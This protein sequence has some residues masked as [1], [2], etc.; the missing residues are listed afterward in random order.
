MRSKKLLNSVLSVLIIST[1][2]ISL[3]PC[4]RSDVQA[5]STGN[6]DWAQKYIEYILLHQNRYG[7]YPYIYD[8][9]IYEKSTFELIYL[10]DDDIPEILFGSGR[11]E[12]LYLLYVYNDEVNYYSFP[13]KA[14]LSYVERGGVINIHGWDWSNAGDVYYD[15]IYIFDKGKIEIEAYGSYYSEH[16]VFMWNNE[17]VSEEQYN[18]A[19]GKYIDT[20]RLKGSF[21]E[22]DLTY[23]LTGILLKI[24][25]ESIEYSKVEWIKAYQ[26]FLVHEK[27]LNMGQYY[28]DSNSVYGKL[29]DTD[30]NGILELIL[31]EHVYTYRDRITYLGEKSDIIDLDNETDYYYRGTGTHRV[32]QLVEELSCLDE[33]ERE[34]INDLSDSFAELDGI[35]RSV[36]RNNGLYD[37]RTVTK[38]TIH[39]EFFVTIMGNS[40][41]YSEHSVKRESISGRTDPRGEIGYG[42]AYDGTDAD[43]IL[44]NI[45]NFSDEGIEALHKISGS[46]MYYDNNTYYS[47]PIDDGGFIEYSAYLSSIEN[48][49]G[50]YHIKY[51][52][53]CYSD[54][55]ENYVYTT[56]YALAAYKKIDGIGYWSLYIVDDKPLHDEAESIDTGYIISDKYKPYPIVALRSKKTGKYVTCDIG[57]K[58]DGEY[59][60]INDP[61]FNVNADKVNAYEMFY[62]VPLSDGHVA[63]QT[64]MSKKY[65]SVSGKVGVSDFVKE[66]AVL[67]YTGS[68]DNCCIFSVNKWLREK[69]GSLV[70]TD[71]NKADAFEIVQ[72]SSNEYSNEEKN[73]LSSGEWLNIDS[74]GVGYWHIQNQIGIVKGENNKNSEENVK[75]LRELGYTLM[76]RKDL[77]KNSNTRTIEY[78]NMQC[79]IGVKKVEGI[80]DV[81]VVF[82]GTSGYWDMTSS[83]D[84]DDVDYNLWYDLHYGL[85]VNKDQRKIVTI[86]KGYL[87]MC[88]KLVRNNVDP[89]SDNYTIA[90]FD[91]DMITLNELISLAAKGE[92]NFTILGHSMGG[93]IAQCYALY[94]VDCGIPP[95]RIRGRTFNSALAFADD[96]ACDWFTDWYNLCVISDS[97]P[98]GLVPGSFMEYGMHRLGK[99]IWLYDDEPEKIDF[100]TREEISNIATEKHNMDAVIKSIL[101]ETA[102]RE[103]LGYT[104]VDQ[105]CFFVTNK[106]NV[107]VYDRPKKD[108]DPAYRIED[109][110]T[111]VEI[112]SFTYNDVGNKWYKTKD[113]KF[114]Y[115]N[116]LEVLEKQPV[117]IGDMKSFMVASNKAVLRKGCYNDTEV[118]EKLS[119]DTL[120]EADYGVTNGSGNFWIHTTVNGKT[121]WIYSDHLHW[122]G[123]LSS[124]IYDLVSRIVVDCPVDV[125][126]YDADDVLVASIIDGEVYTADNT[127]INPYMVGSGKYFDIHSDETYRVKIDSLSEG[128]MDYT[129]L[130]DYDA[131]T[132]EFASVKKYEAVN[133]SEEELFE[134]RFGGEISFG[135]ITLCVIDNEGNTVSEIQATQTEESGSVP[136]DL[137]MYIWITAIISSGVLT[138]VIMMI[139]K[140]YDRL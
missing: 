94:L 84:I 35:L 45:Y 50:V 75:A 96:T 63:L 106:E 30:N 31:N 119:V 52:Q 13:R 40:S 73:I 53:I 88:L 62:L 135:D 39:Y 42:G 111:V 129:V 19:Y 134:S 120:I 100:D 4:L 114:I 131:K 61:D 110:H 80:Y 133:L 2:I 101:D 83:N 10:D 3:F 116:N 56:K 85:V 37:Y 126:L 117:G 24:L 8:S 102:S 78:D 36:G 15:N 104:D 49:G 16:A 107:P 38:N 5:K 48:L 128:M 91:D 66:N 98:R 64:L 27:Y 130:N 122:M 9:S 28:A 43:W 12:G 109:I 25:S 132:G 124:Y 137:I 18:K 23:N 87:E 29:Y 127:R 74:K 121:G 7:E 118:L 51:H 97:V 11:D 44:K 95:E 33:L 138:A 54:E 105:S 108:S 99:T 14:S 34:G 89:D 67:S 81:I 77:N 59:T 139:L 123:P 92:A 90:Y 60:K 103:Y 125:K 1:I 71:K 72:I 20:S 58:E 26:D 140:K 70:T 68:N 76:Y 86:H 82:Q 136:G 6:K 41:Y 32:W 79:A 93:A 47:W 113:G 115:S 17:T 69:N 65:M 46:A 21:D 22:Y 112:E 55:E 57:V